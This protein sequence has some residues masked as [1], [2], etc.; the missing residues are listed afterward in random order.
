LM[1]QTFVIAEAGVNHNGSLASAFEMVAAAAA[2][3]ADAVKFQTFVPEKLAS[4][5]AEKAEYQKATT[6]AAEN[7]LD[8]LKKLALRDDDY[9]QLIERCREHDIAFLSTPFDIPSLRVLVDRCHLELLKIPSGEITN[10]PY[11]LEVGRAG[12]RVIMSTGLATLGEVEQALAVLAFGFLQRPGAPSREA[13]AD[14][15][16]ADD[17]QAALREK[18]Q[19]LHCTTEYPA[20]YGDVNLRAMDTLAAAFALPVGLSDHTPGIAIPIAAAARGAVIIEKHFTLDRN[21][22]GPD[23]KASLEP[24]ELKAM[25]TAIRQVDE[26]LGN[27][28]KRPAAS[29]MKNRPIARKSLVAARDIA[30]GEILSADNLEVKRPGLGVSPMDYWERLGTT[31]SRRYVADELI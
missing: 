13:F 16:F 14:A 5:V 21:L 20:R 19:L 28:V 11:L 12:K 3:G 18:V 7:Q 31:A 29:E 6:D 9:L 8:M 22:P 26:A 25:V 24:N 2:T 27:G 1:K 15:F 4:R 23:Q 17:G 10:G 30:A